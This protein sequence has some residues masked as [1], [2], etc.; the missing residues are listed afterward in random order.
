MCGSS[1]EIQVEQFIVKN[2]KEKQGKEHTANFS[3]LHSAFPEK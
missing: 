3:F 2:V 1:A